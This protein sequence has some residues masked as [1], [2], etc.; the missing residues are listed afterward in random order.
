LPL[1]NRLRY[2]SVRNPAFS[3][4]HAAL[5]KS[6]S[7]LETLI[8]AGVIPH[9]HTLSAEDRST[10]EN[11]SPN[12]IQALVSLKQKLGDDFIKRNGHDTANCIL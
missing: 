2:H 1:A 12:E 3:K 6:V 9:D 10:I 11:L 4:N 5:E 8:A 7:H